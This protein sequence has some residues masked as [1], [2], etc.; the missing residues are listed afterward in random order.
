[1]SVF[2]SRIGRDHI[3]RTRAPAARISRVV[4]TASLL[5]FV[6]DPCAVSSVTCA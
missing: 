2:S 4:A 6:C 1:M 5:A 3:S